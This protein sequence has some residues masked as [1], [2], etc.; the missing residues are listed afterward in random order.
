MKSI[1]QNIIINRTVNRIINYFIISCINLLFILTAFYFVSFLFSYKLEGRYFLISISL[2]F[3]STLPVLNFFLDKFDSI[4]SPASYG[5]VYIK[6]VDSILN[7]DSFDEIINKIF[8]LVIKLL[9]AGHGH[10]IC[11]GNE[12][13]VIDIKYPNNKSH[14]LLRRE[15]SDS[16]LIILS[17]IKGPDDIILRAKSNKPND[18]DRAIMKALHHM[19]ADIVVPIYYNNVI[20]GIIAIGNKKGFSGRDIKLLKLVAF[21]LALLSVN[22]YYFY[23]IRKRREVEK[24]YE[25]TTRIQKQFL[26]EPSLKNGRINIKAYHNTAAYFTREFYDIFVNDAVPDDIR[27]SAYHVIGDVK[28]TSI[29]MPGVQAILQSYARLGFS[30]ANTVIKL[31]NF[32]KERDVLN[33]DLMIFHSSVKQAGKFE[34]YCSK[35]P[36][37]FFYQYSLKKLIRL[38]TNN[39][40][41]DSLK[42]NMEPGDLI[43][44]ACSYYS[45]IINSNIL[46]YSGVINRNDSHPIDQIKDAL[47]RT[48]NDFPRPVNYT[49][50][51][52][53]DVED[54][55]LILIGPEGVN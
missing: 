26:P 35:Y 25:L 41:P 15:K 54:Q 18:A 39:S 45:E 53:G 7:I 24:E 27:V 37:P 34:Y 8:G 44:V 42:V 4:I 9:K 22:S 12:S 10:I 29:F 32:V 2:S 19:G 48:I 16:D 30:P 36:A 21:K 23:E 20:A 49:T 38:A 1:I 47:I 14:E 33:G 46:H 40:K 51:N 6:T 11:Y 43:I 31:K 3:L 55:L 17:H 13:D 50:D 28:E 5:D 52:L